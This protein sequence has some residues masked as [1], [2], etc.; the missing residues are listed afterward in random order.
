[1]S[2]P[3]VLRRIHVYTG[4]NF[5]NTPYQTQGLGIIAKKYDY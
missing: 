4:G 1:M 3:Q 2:L 5:I